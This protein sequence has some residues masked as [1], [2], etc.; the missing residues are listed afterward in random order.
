MNIRVGAIW[1]VI[2]LTDPKD[3]GT[4]GR[5]RKFREAGF[6]EKLR[7]LLDDPELDVRD[8]AKTALEYFD[9][10]RKMEY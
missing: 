10:D 1:V 6:E 9:R 5:I 7:N 4:Q 3:A 8:R 2:N